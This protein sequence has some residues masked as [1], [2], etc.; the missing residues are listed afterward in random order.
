M[1]YRIKD[2]RDYVNVG[3]D[4][5]LLKLLEDKSLCAFCILRD[6]E[7]RHL[8]IIREHEDIKGEEVPGIINEEKVL[9]VLIS[10]YKEVEGEVERYLRRTMNILRK[11]SLSSILRVFMIP[12]LSPYRD[13]EKMREGE[14][15]RL[16]LR[17][18]AYIIM[19]EVLKFHRDVDIG[20]VEIFSS[21]IV[22]YPLRYV[23]NDNNIRVYNEFKGKEEKVYENILNLDHGYREYILSLLK[24]GH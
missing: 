16:K 13:I 9:R 12:H 8:H 18:Q 4:T 23:L 19:R 2:T 21:R 6:P 10:V 1:K 15:R 24:G 14:I 17:Y 7:S 22:K 11:I 20:A 3:I 5:S